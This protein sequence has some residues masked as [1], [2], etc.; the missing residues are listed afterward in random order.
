MPPPAEPAPGPAEL[1]AEP[2][3]PAPPKTLADLSNLGRAARCASRN[4]G[5][6]SGFRSGTETPVRRSCRLQLAQSAGRNF[7][8]A[9][10]KHAGPPETASQ[11]T[12]RPEKHRL[13]VYGN[14]PTAPQ[15]ATGGGIAHCCTPRAAQIGVSTGNESGSPQIEGAA[16]PS[17]PNPL[18]ACLQAGPVRALAAGHAEAIAHRAAADLLCQL[19]RARAAG[20]QASLAAVTA[21]RDLAVAHRV[22]PSIRGGAPRCGS[23]S[24]PQL[25]R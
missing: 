13:T 20:P 21:V 23:H 2:P 3:P 16:A 8:R 7:A 19:Q 22:C 24:N 6:H 10:A 12:V 15:V 25:S 4:A 11:P 9:Q 5:C 17:P 18:P 1:A 14:L